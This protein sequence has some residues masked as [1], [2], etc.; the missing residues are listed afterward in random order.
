[1]HEPP[2]DA[3]RL[4][5]QLA[6]LAPEARLARVRDLGG[7][8]VVNLLADEVE[9]LAVA[10]VARGLEVG[11]LLRSI[12]DGLGDPVARARARRARA[13][14]LSYAGR[15]EDALPE[16]GEAAAL[17][18]EVGAG[19]EAARARM[20][21]LHALASL[22]RYDEALR[23]GE[24]A[25]TAFLAGGERRLAAHADVNLGATFQMN[26]DPERALFH[27]DRARPLVAHD[28][29]TLA[30]LDS[31][32]G[33]ALLHLDR[34]A[35]ARDALGSALP[36][37]E[38]EGL[39]W[40]AAIVEGNL[41][42]LAAREGRVH[43]ALF[44]Y[45]RARRNLE[46]DDS[47]ADAARL[48][49][50]QAEVLSL[51]GANTD[52]ID[53]YAAALAVLDEQGLAF[54]AARARAGLG[55]ALVRLGRFSDA[56]PV[57]ERASRALG[58]L[59][60][61]TAGRRLDLIRADALAALGQPQR[62]AELVARA[63]RELHDRPGDAAVAALASGRLAARTG[64]PDAARD[65]LDRACEAARRLDLAPL[66]SDALHER[67]RLNAASGRIDSA[68][69][70]LQAA[71]AQVERVRGTL[72]AEQFRTVFHGDRLGVYEDLVGALLTAGGSRNV[73][74]AFATAELGKNRALLDR[75]TGS[76]ELDSSAGA[77]SDAGETALRAQLAARRAELNRLY[78][79][80]ADQSLGR[81][82]RL[83]E[84][85]G[86]TLH[87]VEADLRGLEARLAATRG[88]PSL[89]SRTASLEET[90]AALGPDD[91]LVQY[92]TIRGELLAF[93]V[94]RDR[95]SVVRGLC[96]AV[97]LDEAVRRARFQIVRGLRP[98]VDLER[99]VADAR[100]AL[101]EVWRRAFSVVHPRLS[102]ARRIFVA[103]HGALH[104][105]PFAALFDGQRHVIEEHEIVHVPSASV[106]AHLASSR[107]RTCGGAALVVGVADELAPT[108]EDEAAAVAASLP[109][110]RFLRGAAATVP[111]FCE[112]AERADL[113]HVACHGFF[114]D[115][116]PLASGLR[117]ADRWLTLRDVYQLRLEARLVTLSGCDT[118]RGS[119]GAGDELI[120]LARAVLAAGSRSLLVSLWRVDDR[121]TTEFMT[122]VY[123]G[124]ETRPG[125]APVG[126]IG[127]KLRRVQLEFLE[128]HRHPA[129]WAP[130]ILV[131]EA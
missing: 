69:L 12:A 15:F 64:R 29:V 68:I 117:L 119:V 108:I 35:E 31:N 109:N 130:F 21:S 19:L 23:A 107:P 43:A 77:G 33:H 20:S 3:A 32:R 110:S 42:E 86:D 6:S 40:A 56:E 88:A 25:R 102:D 10:E 125:A 100:R 9:R 91:A 57:L 74:E 112:A 60:H 92:F 63:C 30:K 48:Q 62:A 52:A 80:L 66:L 70:D 49:A 94:R 127:T 101:H 131:G 78:S 97:E 115:Q 89:F 50:E 2:I 71:V 17:A 79:R 116:R 81:T 123:A 41:A 82:D 28:E 99:V 5:E 53:A 72:Q 90:Q 36:V 45:E 96:D 126:A 122:R 106:L 44:H 34:F 13:Q 55:R 18:D 75:M 26:D 129:S 103:P 37:F 27:F 7:A 8:A 114:S 73:A 85:W 84:A 51:L 113:I 98:G 67:G 54:E 65:A 11:G 14:A 24:A 105:V 121:I 58:E 47:P 16:Y 95:L 118:G 76:V 61:A 59:G 22:G 120:G 38:R 124:W 104:S 93:V 83:P 128:R 111:T 87:R 4:V 1:M 46:R 39:S